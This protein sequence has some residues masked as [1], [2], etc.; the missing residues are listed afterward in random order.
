MKKFIYLI[1][2][3]KIYKSFYKD[4]DQAFST[5]K[6]KYFQ[7]RFKKKDKKSIIK[8]AK[9][10]KS[11]ALRHKVKLIINDSVT[12][13]KIVKADGCHIGQSDGN[14][15]KARKELKNKILGSTCHNSRMLINKAIKNNV[16]YI[17]L[18][19]FYKSKLKP[20]A[21]K[22]DLK[23]L[24]WARKITKKPIIA[25]GGINHK[26]YKKLIKSGANYIALS[27]FIWNNKKLKPWSAIKKFN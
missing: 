27:S 11:I 10:V 12:I 21:I 17:A 6:V 5:K 4:L 19:S 25:I 3:N 23:N 15:L 24:I 9:N 2:P 18:G 26:N 16:D 20:R 7:I 1:S 8:I 22:A 14:I 13:T